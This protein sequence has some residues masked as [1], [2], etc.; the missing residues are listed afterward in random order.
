MDVCW[1]QVM[2]HLSTHDLY[3]TSTTCKKLNKCFREQYKPTQ[4]SLL[5]IWMSP[6]KYTD[7][8]TLTFYIVD[9]G[10]SLL[11]IYR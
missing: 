5:R 1:R 11:I 8:Q 9:Q 7:A 3:Q 6:E 4:Q 10:N 2:S